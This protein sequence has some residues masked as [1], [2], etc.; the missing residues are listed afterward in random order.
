MRPVGHR[1]PLSILLGAVL[2][3]TAFA[4]AAG[5]VTD[6]AGRPVSV[7]EP[8]ERVFAAGPPAAIVLF[9]LAPDKLLGWTRAPSPEEAAYLPDAYRDLPAHGRLTGRGN[10]ANLEVVLTLRPDLVVDL[11]SVGPTYA[12]LADRV[13]AQT[14][15][16]SMLLGG[17]LDELPAAYRLL[18]E[19]LGVPERA[20]RLAS[21]VET[22][23]A[24]VREKVAEI[25]EEEGPRVYYARGPEGL[26]TALSGSIN[27]EA[28]DFVGA[29]NVAGPQGERRGTASVSLEQVILWDPEII[30][31]VEPGF[32]RQVAINPRWATIDAVESGRI[33]VA[34]QYPFPWIDFPPS[35]NRVLGVRWLAAVLYPD[36]FPQPLE[37]V[38]REFYELFYMKELTEEELARLLNP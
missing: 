31:T 36:L 3:S 33:F 28:M 10:T 20:D 1:L 5:E 17:R 12:D 18:G 21:Y 27:F 24:D 8:V 38:T 14:G 34:P 7:P 11:G 9:T 22:T 30:L 19:V 37:E 2:A 6:S 13:T 29:R 35:V 16:P 25:P 26:D 4:A 32:A 15:V 23:L